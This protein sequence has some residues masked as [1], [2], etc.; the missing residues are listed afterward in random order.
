VTSV[1]DGL[2]TSSDGSHIGR[3]PRISSNVRRQAAPKLIV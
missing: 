3:P 1:R 2:L